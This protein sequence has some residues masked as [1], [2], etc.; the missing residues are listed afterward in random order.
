MNV[1]FYL[2]IQKLRKVVII[3]HKTLFCSYF[4]CLLP[5]RHRMAILIFSMSGS[6]CVNARYAPTA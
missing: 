2:S 5:L 4:K 6:S 3:S 1:Y